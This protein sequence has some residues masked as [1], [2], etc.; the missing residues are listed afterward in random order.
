DIDLVA[1]RLEALTHPLLPEHGPGR[2]PGR[3]PANIYRG[4]FHQESWK[5][6]ATSPNGKAATILEFDNASADAGWASPIT[7]KGDWNIWDN[8]EGRNCTAIWS[9]SKPV[10]LIAGTTLTFEMKFGAYRGPENL[11]HFRLSATGDRASFERKHHRF[12]AMQ[13]KDPWSKL[14]AA[15]AV[16]GRNDDAQYFSRAF[17]RA[18][19]YEA[20]KPIVEFAG[21][22]DDV[23]SVLVQ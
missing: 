2:Y 20:R 19:G 14:A 18:D 12:A 21:R 16:N 5:V 17:Q 7:S 11:G 22:F 6:T 15:Y 3:D 10:S 9:V 1:V 4:T 13:L 8:G 23:L